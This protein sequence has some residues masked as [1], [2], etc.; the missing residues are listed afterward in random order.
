MHFGAF[1]VQQIVAFTLFVSMKSEPAVYVCIKVIAWYDSNKWVR[2]SLWTRA[3]A[4]DDLQ[5]II[6]YYTEAAQNTQ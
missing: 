1:F 2:W 6:Y 5:V 4:V 3:S